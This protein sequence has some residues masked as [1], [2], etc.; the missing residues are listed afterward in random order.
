MHLLNGRPLDFNGQSLWLVHLLLRLVLL[1][2]GRGVRLRERQRRGAGLEVQVNRVVRGLNLDDLRLNGRLLV[3]QRAVLYR[4]TELLNGR[5][6]RR[7]KGL[8]LA[9]GEQ[10]VVVV[11]R[12]GRLSVTSGLISGLWT[13]IGGQRPG[14]IGLLVGLLP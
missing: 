7:L 1:G 5:T 14:L 8:S 9:E 11:G 13:S 4:P 10:A 3:G 12:I 2:H 6:D